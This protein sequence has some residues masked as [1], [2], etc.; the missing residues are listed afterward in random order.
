MLTNKRV[1]WRERRH[2]LEVLNSEFRS[3]KATNMVSRAESAFAKFNGN[4]YAIACTNGT[5]TLHI[6]LEA[7]GV[8]P[9]D[10]VIVPPLTMAAT[11]YAVL[12]ANATP[13]FADVDLDTWQLDPRSVKEKISEKT[14]A[15]ISVALYGTCPDYY[16]L[17]EVMGK[18]PL[19]ED[20]AEAVGVTYDG[21]QIGSF[22]DFSSYSFQSS[23]HL[24]AGEGGMLC[25]DSQALADSARKIQS[26][27][28][29]G[30]SSNQG[31]ISKND[32]Q[33][34]NYMRHEILGWNYRMSDITA[35]VVLGQI[36]HAAALLATRNSISKEFEKVIENCDWL[37]AQTTYPLA[38]HSYWAYSVLLI[39]EGLEWQDF[40]DKF[41]EFGGRGIY[42]AWQLNY[43]E[44][45]FQKRAFLG[46]EHFISKAHLNNYA[47]GLCPNAE[48]LQPRILAFR[49]N[50]WT[51]KQRREQ[52]IALKRTIGYFGN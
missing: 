42:A 1:S 3:S 8:G 9:G 5:A 45:V 14:K 50:E 22:G 28:Y 52:V 12:Q 36:E 39:K 13:V 48:F 46:R 35:A 20:N 44:P 32:I 31:K 16:A 40:V 33:S 7:L 43:N 27:G 51:K 18:I 23:K 24:S 26:L 38:T 10:E 11:C 2:V 4:E 49:T 41:R 6:A 34:P 29:R 30:V 15:V 17:K 37:K 47:K 21:K 19:I 25:T